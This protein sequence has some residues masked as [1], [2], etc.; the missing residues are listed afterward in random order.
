MFKIH[1]TFVSTVSYGLLEKLEGCF[2][3]V[4]NKAKHTSEIQTVTAMLLTYNSGVLF[5]KNVHTYC[6]VSSLM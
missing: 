6:L 2:E 1:F 4:I 3:C 5:W